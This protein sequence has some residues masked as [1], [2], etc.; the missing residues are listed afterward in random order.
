MDDTN[1]P[2]KNRTDSDADTTP[3]SV[4]ER[5]ISPDSSGDDDDLGPDPVAAADR[6]VE[7]ISRGRQRIDRAVA[8]IRELRSTPP[9]LETSE[10]YGQLVVAEDIENPDGE[11]LV[12]RPI[13][14]EEVV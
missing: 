10:Y 1:S 7:I 11:W 6:G 3:D 8:Q 9:T 5:P 13:N 14:L 12:G 4:R 2:D